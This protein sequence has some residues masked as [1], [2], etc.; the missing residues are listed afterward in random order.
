MSPA[1]CSSS[2]SSLQ[3]GGSTS[4]SSMYRN[5]QLLVPLV[6]LSMCGDIF[7]F[8]DILDTICILLTP[9]QCPVLAYRCLVCVYVLFTFVYYRLFRRD[10]LLLDIT[11]LWTDYPA[12]H[13][14]MSFMLKFFFIIQMSYWLHCYPELYF[15]KVGFLFIPKSV[16]LCW[17]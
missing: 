12:S 9:L 1:S 7:P 17:S 10:D 14:Q 16:A 8:Q 4:L 3:L 13:A 2:L 11:S 6:S 5:G 15:Q